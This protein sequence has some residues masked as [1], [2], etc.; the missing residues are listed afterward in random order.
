MIFLTE[1]KLQFYVDAI[2]KS[3]SLLN[4]T[5]YILVNDKENKLPGFDEFAA[6]LDFQVSNL[7]ELYQYFI[8]SDVIQF[9][10]KEIQEICEKHK[11]NQKPDIELLKE[12]AKVTIEELKKSRI[13]S[14]LLH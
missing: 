2:S 11:C 7:E 10:T 1:R 12:K 3:E 6:S 13:R 14:S 5:H 8:T 9:K 4:E